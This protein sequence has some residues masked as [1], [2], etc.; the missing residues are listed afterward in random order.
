M[1][2]SII[3][4]A[5][6]TVSLITFCILG[7]TGTVTGA[8]D[9]NG[10]VVFESDIIGVSMGGF[11]MG[12]PEKLAHEYGHTLQEREL[13]MMYMPVVAI[14]SMINAGLALSGVISVDDYRDTYTETWANDLGGHSW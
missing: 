5:T 6:T 9:Y 7:V 12:P 10:V 11:I 4:M 3:Q 8:S 1:I 2:P 13:G 14:P